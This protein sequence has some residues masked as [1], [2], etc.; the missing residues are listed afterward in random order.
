MRCGHT[1]V[2]SCGSAPGEPDEV[3]PLAHVLCD[4]EDL[5]GEVVKSSASGGAGSGAVTVGVHGH[6]AMTVGPQVEHLTPL[7][8][9]SH[10]AMQE[11]KRR[12][13]TNALYELDGSPGWRGEHRR[14][15]FCTVEG[16]CTSMFPWLCAGGAAGARSLVPARDRLSGHGL[17][18]GGGPRC[19]TRGA[20]APRRI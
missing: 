14:T 8:C 11:Y 5:V 16:G 1:H 13:A 19:G 2:Q 15:E 10:A 3:D 4:P 17:S 20:A 12:T 9:A 6:E 18:L 7:A